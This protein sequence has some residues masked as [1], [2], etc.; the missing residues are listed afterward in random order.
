MEPVSNNNIVAN[1]VSLWN[2][3]LRHENSRSILNVLQLC[4]I[5]CKN[6]DLN[7]FRNSCCLGM[8]HRLHAPLS[9]T[10]YNN[11]FDVVHADL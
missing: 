11:E 3:R 4:N 5:Q 9:N 10:N 1:K 8:S 6:N 7:E 2:A